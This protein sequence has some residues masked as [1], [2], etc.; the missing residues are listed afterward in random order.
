MSY[1]IGQVC[2]VL[3]TIAC[4]LV[5]LWKTKFMMLLD[6]MV[7]N[8]LMCLNYILIG[9]SGAAVFVSGVATIQTVFSLFHTHRGSEAA[10]V[11]KGVFLVLYL[12]FG[13]YGL[14]QATGYMPGWNFK[15][16]VE[17]MPIIGS[18]L[19]MCFV[20]VRSERQ[21]RRFLL[22]TDGVWALYSAITGATAF[23]G[24]FFTV[25]TTVAAMYRYRNQADTV[26]KKV[27]N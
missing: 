17:L 11:E 22:L 25:L 26:V 27:M 8:L 18:M 5:P 10:R 12:L 4:I 7:V 15:T 13:V 6:A 1:F 24:Q 2:G 3:A 16:F 20:Y 19:N 9:Q 14:L 21:S 23:F